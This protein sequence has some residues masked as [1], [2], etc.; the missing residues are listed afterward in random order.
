LAFSAASTARIA[1]FPGQGRQ[2]SFD[3]P[4]YSLSYSREGAR[5]AWS[6]SGSFVSNQI[7]FLRPLEDF[8][9]ELVDEDGNPILDS[10]GE[11]ILVI[12]GDLTDLDLEGIGR[13]NL[14]SLNSRLTLGR[15]GPLVT[16]LTAGLQT[17]RFT[18]AAPNLTD[19]DRIS[20]GATVRA[21]LSPATSATVSASISRFE[22]DN[23]PAATRRTTT[24]LRLGFSH[25]VSD[26]LS[27]NASIGP[28]R[29]ETRE[30]GVTTRRDGIGG[31]L[32]MSYA[33][34]NGSIGATSA[35]PTRRHPHQLQPQPQHGAA[36]RV[37][38][39]QPGCDARP[40]GD[41]FTTAAAQLSPPAAAGQVS[42]WRLNRGIGTD[43][44]DNDVARTALSMG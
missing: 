4:R 37:V 26:I 13:R 21:R 38:D 32:G 43:A 33:L 40:G 8:L 11:P 39:G 27:L 1:R 18:D 35:R 23:A 9:V 14:T 12:P 2:T 41:I 30:F 6:L 29:V 17:R 20:L 42:R 22:I 19:S 15:G 24:T 10:D 28:T 5:S 16:T 34:P 31:S 3:D 44:N 25:A 7:R 36:A